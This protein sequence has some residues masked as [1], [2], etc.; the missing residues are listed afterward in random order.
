MTAVHILTVLLTARHLIAVIY[1]LHPHLGQATSHTLQKSSKSFNVCLTIEI[2]K[3][4][5][6]YHSY[7]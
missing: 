6:S 5:L 2:S 3:H 7:Q 1:E 4:K